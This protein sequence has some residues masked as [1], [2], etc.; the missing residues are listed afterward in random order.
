MKKYSL[1]DLE[2]LLRSDIGGYQATVIIAKAAR[3]LLENRREAYR[4]ELDSIGV[5]GD[6]DKVPLSK[7]NWQE[8]VY[9]KYIKQDKPILSALRLFKEGKI[10]HQRIEEEW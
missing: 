1:E 9:K 10:H 5:N 7:E 6:M 4:E 8:A 2:A 3:R